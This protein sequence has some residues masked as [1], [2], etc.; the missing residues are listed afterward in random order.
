MPKTTVLFICPDNA[1]LSP[2]A[3]TYLNAKGK[4]LVRAF[5]A[6]IAPGS[7]LHPAVGKLLDT[8]GLSAE[9]LAPK[10]LDVFLM[11]HAP[12]PDR[13]IWL[14]AKPRLVSSDVWGG[15]V[16]TDVWQIADKRP[17]PV[18]PAEDCADCFNRIQQSI[19]QLLNPRPYQDMSLLQRRVA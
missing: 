9:G 12:V 2:L 13:V 3:E 11:P 16:P 5:S 19:D 6:G 15:D 18:A 10:S 8:C 14:M 4:G 7:Q 1:L 17:H